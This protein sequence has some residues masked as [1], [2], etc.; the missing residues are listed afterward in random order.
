MDKCAEY[1]VDPGRLVKSAAPLPTWLLKGVNIAEKTGKRAKEIFTPEQMKL[2]ENFT[3]RASRGYSRNASTALRD[4]TDYFSK[5]F[6]FVRK[7]TQLTPDAAL[8][9]IRTI[10]GVESLP[11]VLKFRKQKA[12]LGTLKSIADGDVLVHPKKLMSS[13]GHPSDLASYNRYI[14]SMLRDHRKTLYSLK[15]SGKRKALENYNKWL[16]GQP[17]SM[18]DISAKLTRSF[19]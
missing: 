14:E 11:S 9:Q 4:A 12:T 8:E 16:G 13:I 15:R 2:V 7:G 19:S 10:Y 3:Q 17:Q 6:P 1:G 18:E 5:N